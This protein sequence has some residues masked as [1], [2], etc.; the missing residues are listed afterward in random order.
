M[1]DCIAEAPEQVLGRPLRLNA[2]QRRLGGFIPD[3]I[4]KDPTG[5]SV[6]VEVQ[7]F[8]L[9]RYHLYKCLEYRDLLVIE[10]G[11]EPTV[12]LVCES[13]PERY[14]TLIN[15]HGI[16]LFILERTNLISIAVKSCP[17][18]LKH[19]LAKPNS[20]AIESVV[21]PKL[22]RPRRY[23]WR[24]YDSLVQI[25]RFVAAELTQYGLWDKYYNLRAV[26]KY[27]QKP[28]VY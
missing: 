23:K 25:Y 24:Q 2:Q 10:E 1:E 21:N 7:Q 17:N 19:H 6:I 20:P 14:Q 26:V 13:V 9:D 15:T 27:Y 8:A 4:F 12:I 11:L 18:A 16:D 3:L 22:G 5:K 28:K